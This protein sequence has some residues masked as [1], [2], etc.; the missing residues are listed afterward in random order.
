M[1][2]FPFYID[3]NNKVCVVIGGG[4]IA[5]RKIEILSEFGA[6]IIVIATG[7]CDEIYDLK[8]T[9]DLKNKSGIQ[10]IILKMREFLDEDILEGDFVVAATDDTILNS[11]ISELCKMNNKLV[12]VVDVKEECSFVFPAIIKQEELVIAISTGGNSPAMAAKI[13]QEIKEF[14]PVYY[15][16]L[17]E[18][19]GEYREYI[20]NEVQIPEHRKLVYQE[21]IQLA[22][23]TKGNINKD[24]IHNIIKKFN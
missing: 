11:H 2:Y 12:N 18:L 24:E 7:I 4:R 8:K 17:I 19:L 14:I 10:Q 13:K 5:H 3:I 15:S 1:A 21:L 22:E 20:K 16:A 6:T 9:Y 23:V